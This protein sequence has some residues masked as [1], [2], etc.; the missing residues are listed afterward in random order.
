MNAI[1]VICFAAA[2]HGLVVSSPLGRATMPVSPA[3]INM[4]IE[5]M[6]ADCL[7]EGC[8]VDMV[9]D[10]LAELK[11]ESAELTRRQQS[12]LV[13]IGR[14]QV[15]NAS[16]EENKSEIEKLVGAASRSFSVVDAEAFAFPGEPLGYSL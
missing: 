8:P 16:P 6:A 4:G 2:A 7:E 15:L 5:N 3:I 1:G 13:L 14:L 11:A 12:I 10:L 9:T